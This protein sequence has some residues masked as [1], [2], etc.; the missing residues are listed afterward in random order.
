MPSKEW[1][2]K[3]HE[4]LKKY[5]REWYYKNRES[6]KKR[7][8]ARKQELKVWFKTLKS[9]LKCENCPEDDLCCLE[10]HHKDPSKK[11]KTVCL[12]VCDGWSKKRILE[13]IAKC[14][15]LC[16]NCHKKLHDKM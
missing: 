12:M 13:E 11:E 8:T 14:S 4:K 9:S 2:E 1:K 6:E 10:F 15:V 5:R 7:I 16:S 3:N